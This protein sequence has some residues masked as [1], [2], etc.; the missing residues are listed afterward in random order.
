MAAITLDKLIEQLT[1]IREHESGSTPV[2]GLKMR[3]IVEAYPVNL[4][5][6]SPFGV[7]VGRAVVLMHSA[8]DMEESAA[9][10]LAQK[11]DDF[12]ARGMRA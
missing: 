12:I 1:R 11:I 9:R 7:P 3:G 4:F 5:T 10:E 6:T 2:L 8:D